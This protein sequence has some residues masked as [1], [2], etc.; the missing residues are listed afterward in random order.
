MTSSDRHGRDRSARGYVALSIGAL[1]LVMAA[2]APLPE[3]EERD[4]GDAGQTVTREEIARS[5]AR[6]LWD[7]LRCCT[8]LRLSEGRDGRATAVSHRG[9]NSMLLSDTP[10]TFLDGTRVGD[11]ATLATM[12]ADDLESVRVYSAAEAAGR[13]GFGADNGVIEIVTRRR[14]PVD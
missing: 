4:A 5:R 12:P 3:S 1:V 10:L 7:V 11:I 14:S 2:C 13:F 9:S 8:D 6:T